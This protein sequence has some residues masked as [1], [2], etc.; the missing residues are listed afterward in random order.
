MSEKVILIRVFHSHRT[1]FTYEM[2]SRP[3]SILSAPIYKQNNHFNIFKEATP[4]KNPDKN[5]FP[6]KISPSLRENLHNTSINRSPKI[7]YLLITF[8]GGAKTRDL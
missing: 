7:Q 3:I 8:Q 1:G 5:I 4:L 6:I 2:Y